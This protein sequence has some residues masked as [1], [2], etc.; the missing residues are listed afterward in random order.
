MGFAR[1]E[2]QKRP[3]NLRHGLAGINPQE[4]VQVQTLP[5]SDLSGIGKTDGCCF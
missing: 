3:A 4:R 2:A 1:A 5:E